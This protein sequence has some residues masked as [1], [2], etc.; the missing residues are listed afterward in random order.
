MKLV[1]CP[2]ARHKFAHICKY[3]LPLDLNLLRRGTTPP[4][5]KRTRLADLAA[6]RPES[7]A[8]T[9]APTAKPLAAFDLRRIEN[10]AESVEALPARESTGYVAAI[11][12]GISYG[13][14]CS[15]MCPAGDAIIESGHFKTINDPPLRR[16][17]W[18]H[19]SGRVARRR[20]E[21]DLTSRRRLPRI[22][23]VEGS[24]ATLNL[25]N[26]HNY[27]HW[28]VEILPRLATLRQMG[29]APDYFLVDCHTPSQRSALALLGIPD[30]EL[31]Q[32]HAG[33]MLQASEL[34]LPCF[35]TP[36]CIHEFRA[37]FWRTV[38]SDS[39][40]R[41][42][43]LPR[44][45][46]ISR[47]NARTRR[48]END[49][50]VESLLKRRGFETHFLENYSFAEQAR[51]VNNADVVVGVHGAGLANLVFAHS[52]ARVVEIVDGDRYNRRL[53]PELSQVVGLRHW[54]VIG[55]RTPRQRTLSLSLADLSLA[56]D[57]AEAGGVDSR[58]A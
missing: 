36:G 47:R 38:R 1:Q 3:L 8:L 16:W 42:E 11:R 29:F 28:L 46:F 31:I 13:R 33:L 43:N 57:R 40:V 41:S 5:T 9:T 48:L 44:R 4:P 14:S 19:L 37:M 23:C 7:V 58:A 22:H 52:G 39:T 10:G 17:S 15:V 30:R 21:S 45:L 18:A 12:D 35:P 6:A 26:S 32:P 2:N 27:Y 20:W 49:D 50:E 25:R 34:L 53:Y 51:L 54:Q 55:S 24:V 56:I